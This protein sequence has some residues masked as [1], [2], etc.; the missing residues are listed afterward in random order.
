MRSSLALYISQHLARN[1]WGFANMTNLLTETK[2]DTYSRCDM[3]WPLLYISDQC[4]TQH[5]PGKHGLIIAM[6]KVNETIYVRYNTVIITKKKKNL[7]RMIRI[8]CQKYR[9]AITDAATDQSKIKKWQEW[10]WCQK[11]RIYKERVKWKNCFFFKNWD[12]WRFSS[13]M[14]SVCYCDV[15]ML[16]KRHIKHYENENFM[17]FRWMH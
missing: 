2:T 8:V 13:L 17:N 15:L 5:R 16:N 9:S 10:W 3:T 6:K 12:K 7:D 1:F 14:L 4:Q 11:R